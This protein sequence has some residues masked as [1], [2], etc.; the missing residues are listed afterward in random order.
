MPYVRLIDVTKR[1]GNIEALDGVTF[2]IR[3]GEYLC[4]LGPTGSG[5]TTLLR[6]LA[7]ILRPDDGEIHVDEKLVNRIPAEER[8]AVYVPQTYALFPHM[9]VLQ[10]A[11]F[12]PVARGSSW[13]DA[14]DAAMKVLRMVRLDHRTDAYPHE[15]SGGM[16]QRVALARGLA[17]GA[18]LLLLDEPLGALDARLR[19]ELRGDLRRLAELSGTTVVHVTH[20]QEEAMTLGD[21][22]LLLRRGRVQQHG[23]P[24]HVHNRPENI[25][26]AHFVGN[27]NFLEGIVAQRSRDGCLVR[28]RENLRLMVADP[29]HEPEEAVIVAVRE[30][31]TRLK[32]YTDDDEEGLPGDVTA[33]RFLGSFIRFEVRLYNGDVVAARVPMDG[34]RRGI[35]LKDRVRI[36]IDPHSTMVYE[37]PTLGL[38]RE[39]EAY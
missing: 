17:S 32:P 8:D 13:Q 19:I 30:E 5:K 28:L 35:G 2:D 27:S 20:D 14:Q 25:F 29:S 24:F 38:Q 7:G 33:V 18:R 37:Y 36:S 22:V 6:L 12:G 11:A 16:Q 26:A 3:D 34:S 9:T 4:V 31:E 1:F 21:R 10:N 39:L 15:L 23:T